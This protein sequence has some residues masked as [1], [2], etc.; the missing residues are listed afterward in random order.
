M[1]IVPQKSDDDPV[2]PK[3]KG[4]IKVI[5][6][7]VVAAVIIIAAILGLK[8][9]FH[10]ASKED[11]SSTVSDEESV[12]IES[13]SESSAAQ[14][15]EEPSDE[16]A[17]I[18]AN[19]DEEDT[20]ENA[21][22]YLSDNKYELITDLDEGETIE[23]DTDAPDARWR[24]MV[25]FSPDGKYVYY[26]TDWDDDAD[27]GTLCRAEYSKLKDSSTENEKYIETIADDVLDYGLL[28]DNS[29]VYIDTENTLY[30]FD[31]EESVEIAENV[32]SFYTDGK[33]KILYMIEKE[34]EVY[35]YSYNGKESK[36]VK[37]NVGH[38][39]SKNSAELYNAYTM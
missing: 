11:A 10:G 3:K 14:L 4:N 17:S 18:V 24:Y 5:I 22:I 6:G 2:K 9:Y 8:T 20:E 16:T 21:I 37:S 7:I 35:I 25:F 32:Y 29:V 33:D 39:C 38:I 23:I 31:G 36:K 15:S 28:G 34:H 26:F 12:S 27:T 13:Q 1:V 30:Y 19:V